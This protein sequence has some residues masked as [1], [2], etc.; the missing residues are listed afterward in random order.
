MTKPETEPTAPIPHHQL[1]P[2]D[3]L[4]W[5]CPTFPKNVH[6]WRVLSVC[7]GGTGQ[8]GLIEMESLT[9]SPGHG[10]E[11]DVAMPIV[12]VPEVLARALVIEDVGEQFGIASA[13]RGAK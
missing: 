3:V 9:H 12:I 1:R 11:F 10:A 2:G 13:R 6:R 4:R 5:Q 8:E 7:L